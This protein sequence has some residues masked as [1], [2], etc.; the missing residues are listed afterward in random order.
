MTSLLSGAFFDFPPAVEAGL[1]FLDGTADDC[2]KRLNTQYN[3]MSLRF[4]KS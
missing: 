3:Y 2:R 1:P 4:F